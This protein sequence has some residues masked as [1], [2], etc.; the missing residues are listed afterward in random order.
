MSY[1]DEPLM[2]YSPSRKTAAVRKERDGIGVDD[3]ADD[4]TAD[5][6]AS[7]AVVIA[8]LEAMV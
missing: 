5:L 4:L 2:G 7:R 1:G 3:T 6:A 8:D